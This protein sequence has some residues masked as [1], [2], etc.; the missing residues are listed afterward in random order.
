MLDCADGDED[1]G[2][3]GD[4]EEW[5]HTQSEVPSASHRGDVWSYSL[6]IQPE[7]WRFL[8]ALLNWQIETIAFGSKITKEKQMLN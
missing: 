6:E 2:D 1:G 7:N 3:D 8:S 5:L 4:S